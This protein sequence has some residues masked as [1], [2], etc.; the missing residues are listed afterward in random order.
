MSDITTVVLGAI[1][2]APLAKAAAQPLKQLSAISTRLQSELELLKE[3]RKSVALPES[4][5][6]VIVMGSNG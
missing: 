1:M 4:A 6:R 5:V 3:L 2:N